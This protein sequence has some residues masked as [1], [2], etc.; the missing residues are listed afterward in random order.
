MYRRR[1]LRDERA[2]GLV[3]TCPDCG[4]RMTSLPEVYYDED[5]VPGWSIGFYCPNDDD[6]YPI[7]AA[8]YQRLIDEITRGVDIQS[9]P[10]WP[11]GNETPQADR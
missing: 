8:K 7:W 5:G 10:L 6:T 1:V 3:R 11:E 9:L 2:A 4:T